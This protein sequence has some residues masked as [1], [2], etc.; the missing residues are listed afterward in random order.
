MSISWKTVEDALHNWVVVG[1]GLD[2]QHVIW[3]RQSAPRPT[4]PYIAM[5]IANI[6]Q[7]GQ[8]WIKVEDNV[9]GEAGEEVIHKARGQRKISLSLQC[10]GGESSGDASSYSVLEL[11]RSKSRLPTIRDSLRNAGVGILSIGQITSLDGIVGVVKFEP[12][13][14][15]ESLLILSSEVTE[16]GTYIETV[17]VTNEITDNTFTVEIPS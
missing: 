12:R 3:S 11:V 16:L 6:S 17:K 15:L 10:F 14:T 1:S 2:T 5:S 7:V 9:G 13:A 8:D 4:P